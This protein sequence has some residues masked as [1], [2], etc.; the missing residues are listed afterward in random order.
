M[1]NMLLQDEFLSD[2]QR[3][4]LMLIQKRSAFRFG[5]DAVLLSDFAKDIR[6]GRILDLCTGSGIVP[7]LLYA[8]T[9]AKEIYGVEIQP[10]IADMAMRSA[11]LNKIENRVKI[12][13]ADL[14]SLE[15]PRHSFDLVTC[16]PPYMKAGKA[17]LNECDTKSISRHE[18]LCTL[19]DAVSAAALMLREKGHLVMVH[20]PARLADVICSMR[21]HRIEPKRLRMVIPAPGKAPAL[22]LIDG[23]LGGGADLKVLPP[24]ILADENGLES[25]E[26]KRIYGREEQN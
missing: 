11:A 2:L 7:V 6:G 22:F 25:E 4:G 23:A 1:N 21:E 9:A 19:D 26:L 24:L 20:R 13:C 12:I 16:N 15:L 5:T 8:K 14:R 10:D 18:I 17:L 3:D